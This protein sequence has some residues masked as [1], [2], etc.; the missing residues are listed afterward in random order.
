MVSSAEVPGA[1]EL[2]ISS[3]VDFAILIGTD[4][5][6]RLK[7]LGPHRALKLIQQHKSIEN[8]LAVTGTRYLPE[9]GQSL[10]GFLR[11]VASAR[12]VFLNLPPPP[13]AEDL[14]PKREYDSKL[15][16]DILV[17][18]DLDKAVYS[19]E[20]PEPSISLERDHFLDGNNALQ[21][22]WG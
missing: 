7:G 6:P 8:V 1:L 18:A 11:K 12:E 10:E 21:G 22:N 17:R 2:S 9:A 3:F 20:H 4:F 13:R 15:I 19:T 16:Y 14:V 5:S